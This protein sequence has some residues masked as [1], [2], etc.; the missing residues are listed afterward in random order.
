M[1]KAPKIV[2]NQ[3]VE[4]LICKLNTQGYSTTRIAKLVSEAST[5]KVT[6]Q[7]VWKYLNQQS[8]KENVTKY[9]Q[10]Y[11]NDPQAIS[12]Y[13]KTVRLEDLNRERVRIIN[14]ID[15][16]C[17]KSES[18]P[19]KKLKKYLLL[20]KRLV[21]I[22]IAGREEVEKRPDLVGLFGR[23]GPFAEVTDADLLRQRREIDSQLVAIR[24]N[25]ENA[26]YAAGADRQGAQETDK[27]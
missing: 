15:A 21:D 12:I 20:T 14:T 25:G 18:V 19:E 17:G 22:E 9:S 1:K 23:I 3:F 5:I 27:K 16:I 24:S 6:Q 8:T 7:A 26:V 10:K 4:E 11:L 2:G 13:H